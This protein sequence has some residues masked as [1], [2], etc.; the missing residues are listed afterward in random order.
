VVFVLCTIGDCSSFR[1]L[2]RRKSPRGLT[3]GKKWGLLK[4]EVRFY[5]G[6]EGGSIQRSMPRKG[7]N[8]EIRAAAYG[9]GTLEIAGIAGEG[10]KERVKSFLG[11]ERFVPRK[12]R[13]VAFLTMGTLGKSN[14]E[15]SGGRYEGGKKRG[16]LSIANQGGRDSRDTCREELNAEGPITW[17]KGPIKPQ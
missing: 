1:L 7:E 13:G 17:R 16:T 10:E 2:G 9:R 12:G 11:G 15:K 4:E 3:K 5:R 8:I 14:Q 6:N